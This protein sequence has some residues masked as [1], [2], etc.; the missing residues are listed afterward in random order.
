MKTFFKW[1]LIVVIVVLVAILLALA[2][3]LKRTINRKLASVPDYDAHVDDVSLALWR[4]AFELED[5]V[6]KHKAGDMALTI[7]EFELSIK[8]LPLL[9]REVIANM[10]VESPRLRVLARKPI[11]AT[12]KATEKT[13]E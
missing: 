9:R 1:A 13:K 8:W 10:T 12:K 5:V 4:G 7:P 11:E 6:F 2:S 3:L